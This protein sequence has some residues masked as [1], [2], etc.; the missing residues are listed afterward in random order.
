MTVLPEQQDL[1]SRTIGCTDPPPPLFVPQKQ[2]QQTDTTN[3]RCAA[4][5]KQKQTIGHLSNRWQI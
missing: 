1:C 2:L 4:E 3:T 5:N